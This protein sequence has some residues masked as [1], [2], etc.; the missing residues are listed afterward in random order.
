MADCHVETYRD[1]LQAG[2]HRAYVIHTATGRVLYTTWPYRSES[3]AEARARR[4]L[5]EEYLRIE[6]V[7][8]ASRL[9]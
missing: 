7:A 9:W 5:R 4:W 3:S 8:Q 1:A 6:I 2:M